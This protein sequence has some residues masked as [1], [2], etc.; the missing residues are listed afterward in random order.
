MVKWAIVSVGMSVSLATGAVMT[1]ETLT[2]TVKSVPQ[3][4]FLKS[5]SEELIG[6]HPAIGTWNLGTDFVL[7]C[8][9]VARATTEIEN[10]PPV[11][12]D[13]SL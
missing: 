1:H 11:S 4:E 6:N 8:Y 10:D 2:V 9:L 13:S 7:K 3:L 12:L 5:G